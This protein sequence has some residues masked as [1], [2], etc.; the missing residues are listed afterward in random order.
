MK[1]LRS[2]IDHRLST[3]TN[4]AFGKFVINNNNVQNINSFIN[5]EYSCYSYLHHGNRT[6]SFSGE[7]NT[8]ATVRNVHAT[9]HTYTIQP[10]L[11]SN[12]KL[13]SPLLINFRETTGN[14]FGPR[15][16]AS[17]LNL[18]NLYLT[19]SKS[20]KLTVDHIQK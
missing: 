19:C 11:A 17:L 18:P 13:Y 4:P 20:G 9:T 8:I 10:I 7:R 5:F 6:L 1:Y 12:G 15:I 16:G 14:D 2:T 3:P